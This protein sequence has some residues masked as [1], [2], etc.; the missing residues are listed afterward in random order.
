MIASSGMGNQWLD[1]W[2]DL[3][4]I[5]NQWLELSCRFKLWKANAI[6]NWQ[7]AKAK[8]KTKTKTTK[9]IGKGKGNWQRQSQRQ[10][11]KAKAKAIGKDKGN[12]KGKGN[13]Q[14]QLAKTKANDKGKGNWQKFSG[15]F[16]GR[17]PG[18]FS[19]PGRVSGRKLIQEFFITILTFTSSHCLPLFLLEGLNC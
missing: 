7:L 14:R 8:A 6:G 16:S 1:Q 12:G 4:G 9:A 11:A 10:L 2:L 3:T 13:W 17:V 15:W 19:V 18:W 5:K